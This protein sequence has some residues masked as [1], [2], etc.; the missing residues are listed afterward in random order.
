MARATSNTWLAGT[1]CPRTHRSNA[2][3]VGQSSPLPER[4]SWAPVCS[5]PPW[6]PVRRPLCCRDCLCQKP[7]S[8][9]RPLSANSSSSPPPQ[10]SANPVPFFDLRL[11]APSIN[12]TC[13]LPDHSSTTFS[14]RLVRSLPLRPLLGVAFASTVYSLP[15][16]TP[17]PSA[18]RN[19]LNFHSRAMHSKV[20]SE[21][22]LRT[23]LPPLVAGLRVL[24][25]VSNRSYRVPPTPPS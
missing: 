21:C 15:R 14:S 22:S 25:V 12:R 1:V 7:F 19:F 5:G 24:T 10:H 6:P 23:P 2:A 16:K 18:A 13:L 17:P 3:D 20:V 8:P 9:R 4:S 11:S